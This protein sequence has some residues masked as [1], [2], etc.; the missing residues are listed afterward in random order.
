[1]LSRIYRP[2]LC[3]LSLASLAFLLPGDHPAAA[4]AKPFPLVEK[5]MAGRTTL[6]L[7]LSADLVRK[8]LNLLSILPLLEVN[9]RLRG[10]VSLAGLLEIE[11]ELDLGKAEA[12]LKEIDRR[13]V[14]ID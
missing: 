10:S 7:L 1:M 14:E 11:G 6:P 8:G 2:L 3:L 4:Q 9:T 5:A 12:R 13:Q